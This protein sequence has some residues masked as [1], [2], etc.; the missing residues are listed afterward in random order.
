MDL[1]SARMVLVR[2]LL[3]AS[4]KY[5]FSRP[6]HQVVWGLPK[7]LCT[8]KGMK[9]TNPKK[10]LS[11]AI[12]LHLAEQTRQTASAYSCVVVRARKAFRSTLDTLGW[13]LGGFQLLVCNLQKSIG[14]MGNIALGHPV[15]HQEKRLAHQTLQDCLKLIPFLI[16]ASAPFGSLVF[17]LILRTNRQMLPSTFLRNQCGGRN[18]SHKR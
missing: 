8:P 18:R 17:P 16:V 4:I 7:A 9:G 5:N 1:V 3:Q 15:T 10:R 2:N 11:Y 13:F 6:R 12:T 14:C